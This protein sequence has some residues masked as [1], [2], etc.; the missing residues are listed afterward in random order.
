MAHPWLWR[1][2]DFQPERVRGVLFDLDGTLRDTDDE[3]VAR[4]APWL[5]WL[6]WVGRPHWPRRVAR[7]LLMA[8]ETPFNA[9]Y[10]WADRLHIDNLL[11]RWWPRRKAAPSPKASY[12]LVPGVRDMLALLAQHYPLGIVSSGPRSGVMAFL[13]ATDLQPYFRVV[14]GGQTYPRTKPHPEPVIRAAAALGLAPEQVLMVGDTTVDIQAG[15][16]AGAQTVAVLCGFGTAR[17]LQRAGA[18]LGLPFTGDL[19][20]VLPPQ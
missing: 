18:H 14:V 16:A 19:R 1:L 10:A 13:A 2:P 17:E 7:A 6:A 11:A 5:G 12:R 4:L 8:A 20:Y 15:R 3:L 9:L